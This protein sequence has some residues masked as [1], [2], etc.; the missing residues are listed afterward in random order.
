MYL[1]AYPLPR[2]NDMTEKI[3]EY[4]FFT[5]MDLRSAYHH[6]PILENE[7]EVTAFEAHGNLFQ[8]KSIPFGVTNGVASSTCHR[9]DY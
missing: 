4:E 9:R 3:A 8:F 7:K 2:I 5:A 6:V 1:D